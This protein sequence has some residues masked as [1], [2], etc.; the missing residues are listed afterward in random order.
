MCVV[1]IIWVYNVGKLLVYNR[2]AGVYSI[3][4]FRKFPRLEE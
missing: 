1:N 4:I 3:I 2:P